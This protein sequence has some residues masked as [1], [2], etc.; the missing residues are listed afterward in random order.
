M[1]NETRIVSFNV[2]GLLSFIKRR[3]Y[4]EQT[5]SNL[6][7]NICNS[8]NEEY[9][10]L[11]I[12]QPEIICIQECKMSMNEDLNYNVGCPNGYD[13]YFS[14][15]RNN[16]R[17]SGVAT[18]VSKK[19][20][21]SVIE[22]INGFSW[23]KKD[24]KLFDTENNMNN[25]NINQID[26]EISRISNTLD[27]SIEEIDAEGRC[28]ITDH[29][30][31]VVINLYF[32]LLREVSDDSNGLSDESNVGNN[33]NT[34]IDLSRLKYRLAFH[35]YLFL[36]LKTI[37]EYSKRK[38]LLLGDFN[39]VLHSIDSYCATVNA[40]TK[41]LVC[42]KQDNSDGNETTLNKD[43]ETFPSNVILKL[44]SS[45][46]IYNQI[47][48]QILCLINYF[49]LSDVYRQFHPNTKFKYTC[50]NQMNQLRSKNQG[51]RID[52]FL[53]SSDLAESIVNKCE[54]FSHIYGSDHCP[55]V[56]YINNHKIES[57]LPSTLEKGKLLPP[58]LCSKYLPQCKQRQSS[59]HSFILN[60]NN[61]I[62]TTDKNRNKIQKNPVIP[63]C[64]HNA[65]CNK[66][67][68]SKAGKNKGRV[69]WVCSKSEGEK[70]DI[71]I[72]DDQHNPNKK[73][74]ISNF[75]IS[76]KQK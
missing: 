5:F 20:I 21:L 8:D 58:S 43:S 76:S 56:L 73:Q 29:K 17:Y 67:I 72:W 36:M 6:L 38:I 69:Y 42:M 23:L 25:M 18:Y 31:F 40:S 15:T 52:L 28:I 74:D 44:E 51:N 19:S 41:D 16:K 11:N 46:E 62:K 27:Y 33:I 53:L 55:V 1:E 3:G 4:N 64:K 66:K 48:K 2:N 26:N 12:N 63:F 59:I 71:F 10:E 61:V 32:P 70:C 14:L 37:S 22:S 65:P 30:Q 75:V 34:N 68:V 45:N 24:P 7:I 54:I 60:K 49:N 39:I 50:W 9:K 47:K 35:E 57:M 13:S